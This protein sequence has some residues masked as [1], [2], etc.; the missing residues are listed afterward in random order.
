MLNLQI[1]I[2]YTLDFLLAL[3]LLL[4]L[5]PLFLIIAILIKLE[6]RGP[7]F[8]LQERVGQNQRLF[9]IF[10]FRS[11]LNKSVDEQKGVSLGQDDQRITKVGKFLRD[12]SLDEIPQ[13]VN[14]LKG[15]MSFVGPRPTLKYQ[16]DQYTEHQLQRLKMRPGI[17]GYA[18]VNG[19]NSLSWTKRIELDVFYI[20]HYSLWFDVKIFC[21]TPLI[22]FGKK[23]TYGADGTNPDLD[24]EEKKK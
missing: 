2:K 7:V 17:T 8:F 3:L 15:E 24:V 14:I 20:Q 5:A 10:K 16:V 13:L 6:S 23:G 11:M 4:I 9:Q 22:I 1:K 19:R 21:K 18:Q 12:W